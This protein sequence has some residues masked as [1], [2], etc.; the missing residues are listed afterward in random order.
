VRTAK[1]ALRHGRLPEGERRFPGSPRAA[2]RRCERHGKTP[3]ICHSMGGPEL[4]D[5]GN[6]LLDDSALREG[7]HFGQVFFTKV[8]FTTAT[9]TPPAASRSVNV[10]A[11]DH[12]NAKCAE[13]IRSDHMKPAARTGGGI[14]NSLSREVESMPK[15]VPMM[16]MPVE[17]ETAVIPGSAPILS[18]S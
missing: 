9:G 12:A 1:P 7:I 17:A 8:S 16:G 14:V 10:A 2:L 15:F 11:S 13:I 18:M 4:G 3:T 6:Q 5:S